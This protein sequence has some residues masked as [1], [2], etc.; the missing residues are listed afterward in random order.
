MVC[1][2]CGSEFTSWPGFRTHSRNAHTPENTRRSNREC[3]CGRLL[4]SVSG[5]HAHVH[6]ARRKGDLG[7]E[8]VTAPEYHYGN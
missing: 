5:L 6:S 3:A 4:G 1:Q 2:I 7:H 8:R